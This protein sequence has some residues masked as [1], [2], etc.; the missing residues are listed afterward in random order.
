MYSV[1]SFYR[2]N[3]QSKVERPY[4]HMIGR[5]TASYEDQAKYTSERVD[6]II[7]M[8]TGLEFQGR[9]YY[10]T[11]RLFSGRLTAIIYSV[12][13]NFYKRSIYAVPQY[14]V[15]FHCWSVAIDRSNF[16]I[17]KYF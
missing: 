8:M 10:A 6:E 9:T 11:A 2:E 13:N 14:C 7:T 16:I 1:I 5:S 4:L 15:W 12:D 3:V 17:P